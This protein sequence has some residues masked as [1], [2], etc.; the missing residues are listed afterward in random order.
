MHVMGKNH[1]WPSDKFYFLQPLADQ[2]ITIARLLKETKSNVALIAVPLHYEGGY[3]LRRI[4][5]G[6][7]AVSGYGEIPHGV[8][9]IPCGARSTEALL[10]RGDIR[11]YNIVM[12]RHV[13]KVFDKSWF[14]NF[15]EQYG[16]PV[17]KTFHNLRDIPVDAF[18]VFYKQKYEIGGR[19]RG[20]CSSM[21]DLR[22]NDI[23]NLLIQ[24][25]I[26]THGTYGVGFLAFEGKLVAFHVHFESESLPKAGGSGVIVESMEKPD[27][28]L[29]ELT[30]HFVSVFNYSGW[31][32]AEFKYDRKRR[33]YVFMEVNAKFWA[34][35][36]LA[37][38]NEPAFLGEL[39]GVKKEKESV[40][41]MVFL[42][43][44]FER[45]PLFVWSHLHEV[46]ASKIVAYPWLIRSLIKGMLPDWVQ[47]LIR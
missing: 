31:G 7:I 36:E 38:R 45:G 47:K 40:K 3:Y 46:C 42:N 28:R 8:Y 23:K 39:F 18:S 12:S 11:L 2:A 1:A 19:I 20:V 43:R 22:R 35:C 34:S 25:Y 37:F 9:V 16:L 14:V 17:P 30:E 44:A 10:R 33:D 15:C 27:P 41:R 13:L 6:H 32:L 24:E 4:Y 26:D 29:I 5:D 21:K